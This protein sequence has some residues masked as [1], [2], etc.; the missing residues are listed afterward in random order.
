MAKKAS[1][2]TAFARDISMQALPRA[3]SRHSRTPRLRARLP[4]SYMRFGVSAVRRK[5]V[6]SRYFLPATT[7]RSSPVRR[8]WSMEASARVCHPQANRFTA[9]SG[10]PSGENLQPISQKPLMGVVPIIP[11]PFDADEAIDE[12]ALRGLVEF[13]AE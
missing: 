5:L 9:S 12:E 7:P 13:A 3:T 10:A 1:A 6:E 2:L 8:T 4:A 11:T